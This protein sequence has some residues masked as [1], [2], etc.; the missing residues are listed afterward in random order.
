MLV[1][2]LPCAYWL[3]GWLICLKTPNWGE[4][5]ALIVVFLIVGLYCTRVLQSA[6]YWPANYPWD[7]S[8]LLLSL[9]IVLLIEAI[10][11]KLFSYNECLGLNEQSETSWR[12]SMNEHF[13]TPGLYLLVYCLPN[14]AFI[15]LWLAYKIIPREM[16]NFFTS[17]FSLWECQNHPQWQLLPIC[18]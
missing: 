10:F 4:T 3:T 2:I 6:Q 15:M 12:Q 9:F 16:S 17:S 11:I 13:G 8:L 1:G 14:F 5:D 7:Y 18:K